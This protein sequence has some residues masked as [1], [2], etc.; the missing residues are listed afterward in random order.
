MRLSAPLYLFDQKDSSL[1]VVPLGS[2]P[3]FLFFALFLSLF[4]DWSTWKRLWD[5]FLV[6]QGSPLLRLSARIGRN[7][8]GAYCAEWKHVAA[9]HLCL[10]G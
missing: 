2:D 9:L 6:M 10:I 3:F 4:F 5:Q 7:N 8:S 1:K